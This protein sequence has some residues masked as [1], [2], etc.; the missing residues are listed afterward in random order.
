MEY[1]DLISDIKQV[2]KDSPEPTSKYICRLSFNK[3][4]RSSEFSLYFHR[5]FHKND[6]KKYNF[7]NIIA[8]DFI[9]DR[10]KCVFYNSNITLEISID[11]F[12]NIVFEFTIFSNDLRKTISEFSIPFDQINFNEIIS[13]RDYSFSIFNK[14][15]Q[16]L[17]NI[18]F[19]FV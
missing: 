6:Y 3:D 4:T 5:T 2:I 17:K 19:E 7:L 15:N 16:A 13:E 10:N 11:Y 8:E 1:L 18:P 9:E 14:I 12:D